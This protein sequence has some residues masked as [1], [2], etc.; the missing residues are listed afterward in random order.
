[1]FFTQYAI[2]VNIALSK[3]LHFIYL[4][5]NHTFVTGMEVFLKDTAVCGV[6]ANS[7]LNM[8]SEWK[9][10]LHSAVQDGI[11]RGV[12]QPLKCVVFPR[13]QAQLAFR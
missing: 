2:R 3:L 7:L 1:L 9:Q 4:I 8:P 13:Q 6:V 12:V 11:E 5:E 10:A